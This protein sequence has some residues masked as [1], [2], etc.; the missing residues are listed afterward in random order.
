VGRVLLHLA[1]WLYT[2]EHTQERN[3]IAVINVKIVLLLR[4][5]WLYTREHTQERNLIAVINVGK[6]LF[7][8]A[9]DNTP[10]NTHRRETL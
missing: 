4:A 10:E 9:S 2:R 5:L 8:L 7:H 1:V 6:V 3:L